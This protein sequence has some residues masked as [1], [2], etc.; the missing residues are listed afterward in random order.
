MQLPAR[1]RSS[2]AFGRVGIARAAIVVALAAAVAATLATKYIAFLTFADHFVEDWETA[3]LL[4]SEPQSPDI[5]IVAITESTLQS[6]PYRSP[7]DRHFMSEL[8]KSLEEISPRAIGIDLL[9]DQ[10]TETEKDDELRQT[11]VAA[12]V[13]L[14]V[15][16]TQAPETVDQRQRAFERAFV[17]AQ[18][19]ALPTLATD[20]FDTVRWVYP[21][22]ALSDGSYLDSFARKLAAEIGISTPRKLVPIA[23]RGRPSREVAPFAEYP[24]ELIRVLPPAWFKDK[25]VLIG[26]DLK[27]TDRHRTPFSILAE[28][29]EGMLPGVV[30]HAHSLAQF[31]DARRPPSISAWGN[32][33]ITLCLAAIGAALPT[34]GGPMGARVSAAGALLA[35]FWLGGAALFHYSYILIGLLAPTLSMATAQWAME[36]ICGYEARRHREFLRDAFSRYVSPKVVEALIR[37]PSKVSLQGERRVMTFLFTDLANFTPLSEALDS[38]ELASTLNAY[39]EGVAQIVLKYDGTI[40]KFEGDAVFV[41]FNAPVDLPNH[42]ARAVNCAL[43]LDRFAEGFRAEQISRRI[44]FGHTR[45]GIHT[46]AAVVGNF[47]SQTRFEY[48]ANGDAVNTAAR[49]EGVNKSF[50]TRICVSEAT[51][52]DCHDIAFRPLGAVVVKGKTHGIKIFEPLHQDQAPDGFLSRYRAAY[53]RLESFAPDAHDML[54]SLNADYPDDQ[55]I[56]LHL[57]RLNRGERGIELVLTEK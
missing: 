19:R 37:D 16:Y 20:Q 2:E 57:E 53:E 5:V 23:W 44:P 40:A 52:G 25:V 9:F 21:G 18:L 6:F 47:G 35:S 56:A 32:F 39:F 29:A 13:P 4:S 36:T 51:R 27:L 22:S 30:I 45:I 42:P 49:L 28:S 12:K 34:F 1:D 31:I 46:G 17:P 11:L 48:S 24:A 33:L 3:A 8:V 15:S 7:V 41:I 10:P 43:E 55:C 38:H 26:T 50:G 14:V 54:R